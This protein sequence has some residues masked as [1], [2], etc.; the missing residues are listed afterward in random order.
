MRLRVVSLRTSNKVQLIF[1]VC[2][3]TYVDMAFGKRIHY[4]SLTITGS[5]W[6]EMRTLLLNA[7]GCGL[8]SV[9]ILTHPFEYVKYIK[10]GF[11]NLR[12]NRINQARLTRLC[13]FLQQHADKFES[14]TLGALARDEPI[15][16]STQNAVLR[17]PIFATLGRILENSLNDLPGR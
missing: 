8:D 6:T 5:S 1:E 11:T 10:P 14:A 7:H 3:L 12:P 2:V 16:A 4:K 13:E 17:V 15:R 9:V